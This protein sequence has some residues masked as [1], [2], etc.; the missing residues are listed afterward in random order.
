VLR[1]NA[2]HGKIPV[3]L[4]SIGTEDVVNIRE[5]FENLI[6][7]YFDKNTLDN[8]KIEYGTNQSKDNQLLFIEQ[9][10]KNIDGGY[11]ENEN[12][13]VIIEKSKD[14]GCLFD[15]TPIN[16][17][18]ENWPPFPGKVTPERIASVNRYFNSKMPSDVV[19]QSRFETKR[20]NIDILL[21]NLLQLNGWD[22][23]TSDLEE[24]TVNSDLESL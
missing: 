3:L 20:E 11:E 5:K 23:S 21:S 8:L 10:T 19:Q 14:V 6:E 7:S 18:Q 17:Q 12:L 1:E 22:I 15:W 16:D 4:C 24:V 9:I 2:S 13:K